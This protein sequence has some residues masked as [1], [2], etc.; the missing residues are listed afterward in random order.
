MNKLGYVIMKVRIS[1]L[2][3]HNSIPH[4]IFLG[5]AGAAQKRIAELNKKAVQNEYYIDRVPIKEG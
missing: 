4:E 1:P 2:F 3:M 5:T